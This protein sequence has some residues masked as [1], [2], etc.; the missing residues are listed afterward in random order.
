MNLASCVVSG[1]VLFD[2]PRH[3]SFP[4]SLRSLRNIS[5][6]F[7]TMAQAS[8][9]ERWATS[10]GFKQATLPWWWKESARGAPGI[11][12]FAEGV[13]RPRYNLLTTRGQL[14]FCV[15]EWNASNGLGLQF[16]RSRGIWPMA[17]EL[18]AFSLRSK[19]EGV[20]IRDRASRPLRCVIGSDWAEAEMRKFGEAAKLRKPERVILIA[21]SGVAGDETGAAIQW[22]QA[23]GWVEIIPTSFCAVLGMFLSSPHT[24]TQ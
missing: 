5:A 23:W 20:G 8:E 4:I 11:E 19:L 21:P 3:R 22:I 2:F 13:E 12:W 24:H 6:D 18:R 1:V 14:P 10:R 7:I 17:I 9:I 15:S 16:W